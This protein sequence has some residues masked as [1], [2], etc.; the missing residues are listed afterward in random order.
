M[1]LVGKAASVADPNANVKLLLMNDRIRNL[2]IAPRIGALVA[3]LP[4]WSS[5][6][7]PTS[8][9][10]I[11]DIERLYVAGP[12]FRVSADVVAVLEY[13]VPQTAMRRAIDA[14]VRREPKGEWLHSKIPAARARADRAE[15]VFVLP[16]S[17]VLLMVPPY[18][19]DDALEKASQLALPAVGGNA[20]VVAFVSS[21]WRALGGL[22]LPLEVPK[23]IASV[24]LSVTPSE[25][26][27][28]VLHLDAVDESNDAA[29]E[30]AALLTAAINA[31]TQQDVGAIGALFFGGHTLS[32]VEP[33]ELKADA[34]TIRGDARITPRQLDRL[35]G[36][37]EGWVDSITGGPPAVPSS[38]PSAKRPITTTPAR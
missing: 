24:A 29:K 36:F 5:F 10:P 26:G 30:H 17:K 25:D 27:G 23:S 3:R 20:A 1:A 34:K 13:Q 16:K 8:L 4:Q 22:R 7:G 15:R 31:V 19:V 6:F 38:A 9:D 35:L 11:R 21:P 32:L 18:L 33:I 14:I 12:Q 37:A 28:A 2:P